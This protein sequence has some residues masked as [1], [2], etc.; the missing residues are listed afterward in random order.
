MLK[1]LLKKQLMELGA[2]LFNRSAMGKKGKSKSTVILY[3]LIFVYAYGVIGWLFFTMADAICAPLYEMGQGW[4]YFALMGLMAT[5]MG[6]IMSAFT[7]YAALYKAKDNE[8]LLS[9][10]I[11]PGKILLARMSGCYIMS[12]FF[13]TLVLVPTYMVY[14][15]TFGLNIAAIICQVTVLAVLPLFALAISCV[16]GWLIA[17]VMARVTKGKSFV[18]LL[19][20]IGFL[21]VYF[22][23]YSQAQ[24]YLQMILTNA[25][26]IGNKIQTALYPIYQ[27]GLASEGKILPLVLFILMMVAMFGVVYF[28]LRRNFIRLANAKSTAKKAVYKKTVLKATSAKAALLRREFL[29]LKSSSVYMLNCG[30]GTLMFLIAAVFL[31]VKADL[32]NNTVQS[33]TVLINVDGIELLIG[34][35][36]VA[37]MAT[38]NDF[39]AASVS[40]EG[41]SIWIVRSL[42]AKTKEVLEAK[43]LMHLILT[44]IPIL[45][46]CAAFSFAVKLSLIECV[47]L[48][49]F[50]VAFVLFVAV[51][52]LVINLKMP[53]LNWV[54]ETVAVKQS[55]SVIIV[56]FGSWLAAA[57]LIGLYFAFG[58]VMGAVGYVMFCAALVAVLAAA[59]DIWIRRRGVKIFECL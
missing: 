39:T 53:N 10:P 54:S 6:I 2:S 46:C 4:L 3:A 32:I 15:K 11:P 9:M 19:L 51:M 35:V 30:L 44:A 12:F 52:G 37:F 5:T 21:A 49:L 20:S 57:G 47:A 43:V 29:H 31:A 38:M 25:A 33:L 36:S 41:K 48:M 50:S 40:L 16:L 45:I 18:S 27:M 22:Y 17:K 7:T 28:V 34:A 56:I 13:E 58:K 8:L 26:A 59:A 1:T 42:P 24:A 23:F 55:M 14:A